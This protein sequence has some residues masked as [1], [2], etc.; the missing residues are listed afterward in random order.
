MLPL[1]QAKQSAASDAAEAHKRSIHCQPHTAYCRDCA[2]MDLTAELVAVEVE[3]RE[4][5][6][7]PKLF[8]NTS[9]GRRGAGAR[10][11]RM[12]GTSSSKQSIFITNNIKT[13]AYRVSPTESMSTPLEARLA[14]VIYTRAKSNVSRPSPPWL[15]LKHLLTTIAPTPKAVSLSSCRWQ[16]SGATCKFHTATAAPRRELFSFFPSKTNKNKTHTR[17]HA[18]AHV[19]TYAD[20]RLR[21]PRTNQVRAAAPPSG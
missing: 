20:E 10:R 14:I 13:T 6:Q 11:G 19:Y 17:P 1:T 3:H 21:V 15:H 5:R 12:L 8:R 18:R 9:C 2:C 4:I 7:P 16:M